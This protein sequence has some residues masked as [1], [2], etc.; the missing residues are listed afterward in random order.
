MKA[1]TRIIPVLLLAAV[2]LASGCATQSLSAKIKEP[3]MVREDDGSTRVKRESRPEYAALLP[4]AIAWDIATAP[5]IG[6]GLGIWAL[7]GHNPT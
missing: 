6:I 7:S 2:L 5:L 3:V 4:F 1:M